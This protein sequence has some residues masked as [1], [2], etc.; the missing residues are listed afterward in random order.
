MEINE[1]KLKEILDEQRNEFQHF[2]GIMKEDFDSKIDLIGEQYGTIKEMMGTI[3]EDMQIVKS[4]IEF[5]KGS[6]RKKVDYDEF[7]A[8]ERRVAMLESKVRK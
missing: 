8:L 4:D 5:I 3:A 2:M 1:N 6:L 7:Q